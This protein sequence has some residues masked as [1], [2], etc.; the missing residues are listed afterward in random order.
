MLLSQNLVLVSCRK[1]RL[2]QYIRVY[3]VNTRGAGITQAGRVRFDLWQ[4][5]D[6]FFLYP[7]AFRSGLGSTQPRMQWVPRVH[8]QGVRRSGRESYRLH[9]STVG[10][11]SPLTNTSYVHTRLPLADVGLRVTVCTKLPVSHLGAHPL[12]LLR[13]NMGPRQTHPFVGSVAYRVT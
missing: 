11:V 13:V 3:H 9:P 4:R 2:S 12:R 5:Q 1:L 7:T 10:A 6:I 8:S